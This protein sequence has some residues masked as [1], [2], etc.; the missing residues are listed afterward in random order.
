[1]RRRVKWK[2]KSD[3]NNNKLKSLKNN[4]TECKKYKLIL[5]L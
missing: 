1:M 4:T 3:K 2:N 5:F